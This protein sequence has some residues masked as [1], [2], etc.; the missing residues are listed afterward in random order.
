MQIGRLAFRYRKTNDAAA[1]AELNRL[2][3]E[4]EKLPKVWNFFVR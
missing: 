2:N 3:A 4:L 1:K